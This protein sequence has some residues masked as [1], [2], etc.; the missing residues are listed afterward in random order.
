MSRLSTKPKEDKDAYKKPVQ[1][2]FFTWLDLA[3]AQQIESIAAGLGV[4][5]RKMCSYMI[6]TLLGNTEIL[7]VVLSE[8]AKR[9][10]I[11]ELG[12][13][14]KMKREIEAK[15]AILDA[16]MDELKCPACGF[17]PKDEKG[18]IVHIMHGCPKVTS[19]IEQKMLPDK[20]FGGPKI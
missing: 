13:R 2:Q 1:V 15:Q 11:A 17:K 3:N 4:N 7:K 5:Q 16:H 12:R 8:M 19:M 10:H 14:A 20:R 18:M 6:Q 9:P